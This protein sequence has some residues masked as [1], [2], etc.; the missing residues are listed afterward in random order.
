LPVFKWKSNAELMNEVAEWWKRNREQ[1]LNSVLFCYSL[2]KAQRLLQALGDQGLVYGHGAVLQ[3]NE[4]LNVAGHQ[5]KECLS[6]D[7]GMDIKG[8]LILAPPS[9]ENSSWLKRFGDFTTRRRSTAQN[10]F[11]ISDHADWPGLLSA[12]KATNATR[13][14]TTHGYSDILTRFLN[15]SGIEALTESTEFGEE[16]PITMES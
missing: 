16:E 6:I 1:G 7:A 10:G 4:A 13:V 15:E 2:G 14:I 9:A 12:I 11:V 3:M 5:L 8:S